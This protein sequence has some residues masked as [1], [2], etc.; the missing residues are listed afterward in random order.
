MKDAA[1]QDIL[2]IQHLD[3]DPYSR[4]A[5]PADCYSL[6]LV[7]T[8]EGYGAVNGNPFAY[9]AGDLFLIGIREA[10]QFQVTQPTTGYW[11]S[12]S[13]AFV[14]TLLPT[15]RPGWTCLDPAAWRSREA[16]TTDATERANLGALIAILL[17]EERSRRPLTGNPVVEGVMKTLFSLVDRLVAQRGVAA[18]VQPTFSSDITRRV[19]AYISQHIS[20]PQRLRIDTIADEFNYSPGHLRALF[21][22]QVGDSMQQFI[23]R[24]KLKLVAL[25]LRHTSL[26]IA[27]IADEFGFADVCHLNKQFKRQYN[28]TPTF[29]RQGLSA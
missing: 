27:Q 10:Y 14:N 24:H 7:Q 12:F 4:P 13:P 11:L 22:Q 2:S 8:G 1:Q 20:E 5:E 28:H 9:R 6:I 17:S 19:I 23:I 18:P 29:Y 15:D 3:L 25:K 21:R 16:V 26:T